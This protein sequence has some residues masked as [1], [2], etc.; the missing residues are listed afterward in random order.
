M[1]HYLLVGLLR[2]CGGEVPFKSGHE[3]DAGEA[4]SSVK[5]MLREARLRADASRGAPAVCEATIAIYPGFEGLVDETVAAVSAA[6]PLGIELREFLPELFVIE[7][8]Y[9][10]PCRVPF[11]APRDLGGPR[12]LYLI[13]VAFRAISLVDLGVAESPLRARLQAA[14]MSLVQRV[15]GGALFRAAAEE[16]VLLHTSTASP[17]TVWGRHAKDFAADRRL[18]TLHLEGLHGD[19][20][21]KAA[22]EPG[23]RTVVVPYFVEPQ[24]LVTTALARR[25]AAGYDDGAAPRGGRVFLR[26]AAQKGARERLACADAFL[27]IAGSDVQLLQAR[28]EEKMPY[29][30]VLDTYLDTM[31]A[32]RNSTFCLV[33]RGYTATSRRLYEALENGCVPVLLS[34]AFHL[35]IGGAGWDGALVRHDA[36]QIKALPQRLASLPPAA[37]AA[38]K[39]AGAETFRRV[40]YADGAAVEG[41]W[42]EMTHLDAR[43]RPPLPAALVAASNEA[44]TEVAIIVCRPG[45]DCWRIPAA[46]RAALWPGVIVL[47]RADAAPVDLRTKVAADNR[48][49][50]VDDLTTRVRVDFGLPAAEAHVERDHFRWLSAILAELGPASRVL[51]ASSD[52][53]A[54]LRAFGHA[55]GAHAMPRSLSVLA[56]ASDGPFARW[57][58]KCL[59]HALAGAIS[60]TL[61][62]IDDA[63]AFGDAEA[64]RKLFAKAAI[65]ASTTVSPSSCAR[66][67]ESGL[68][69]TAATGALSSLHPDKVRLLRASSA[70]H[71][72]RQKLQSRENT[73]PSDQLLRGLSD[74]A[75]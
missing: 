56:V 45:N 47:A 24:K 6:W 25:A 9:A 60:P 15:V 20:R 66:G 64:L 26:A 71:G 29:A 7:G 39:S 32:M 8:L 5:S 1:R 63:V 72:P 19:T 21:S 4:P 37:V 12:R 31:R 49:W 23:P 69:L 3:P 68:F 13:P 17:Q 48:A 36:R 73:S 59:P 11:D 57:A 46:L 53:V 33:P 22:F 44:S 70:P 10:H 16:H 28:V 51:S 30:R 27:G 67:P 2:L 52:G 58:Q 42:H 18:I 40:D 14:A 55:L 54:G 38:M 65:L 50:L 75:D 61:P 41:L 74:L 43:L 62:I 35:A 34:G